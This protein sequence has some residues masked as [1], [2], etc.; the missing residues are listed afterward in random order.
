MEEEFTDNSSI[1]NLFDMEDIDFKYLDI[2]EEVAPYA[3]FIFSEC[4][5]NE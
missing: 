5:N 4:R 3:K 1:R 2:P